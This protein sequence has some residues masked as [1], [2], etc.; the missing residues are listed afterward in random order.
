MMSAESAPQAQALPVCWRALTDWG[1]I[2]ETSNIPAGK[3]VVIVGRTGEGRRIISRQI[4]A[5]VSER[6]WRDAIGELYFL[7]G[8]AEAFYAAWRAN[9]G[10]DP[11]PK[12]GKDGQP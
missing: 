6:T 12:L 2:G 10:L 8:P 11:L 3:A 7:D 1:F 5:Q 9:Q 4:V